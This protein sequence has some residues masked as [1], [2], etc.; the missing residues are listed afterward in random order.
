[1]N[2]RVLGC[3]FILCISF[4]LCAQVN[5]PFGTQRDGLQSAD[6]RVNLMVSGRVINEDGSP[7]PERV[8]IQTDCWGRIRTQ[9]YTDQNGAFIFT[10][11]N[12]GTDES[13]QT[14]R[15]TPEPIAG[16]SLGALSGCD[17][18]ASLTGYSSARLRLANATG[19]DAMEVGSMVLHHTASTEAFTVS[20]SSLAAPA[21]AEKDF[22]KGCEERA[23]R[24]VVGGHDRISEGGSCLSSLRRGLVRTWPRTDETGR[25]SRRPRLVPDGVSCG[26]KVPCALW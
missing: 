18:L 4:N 16:A 11:S 26:S 6:L 7:P 19:R 5:G 25:H 12:M 13:N 9:T 2:P 14:A 22:R 10:L 23:Q 17:L 15:I 24:K 21:K 3:V 20:A 1:M 8:A